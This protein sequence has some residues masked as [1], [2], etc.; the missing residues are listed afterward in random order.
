MSS[1]KQLVLRIIT[2]YHTDCTRANLEVS[3]WP[4]NLREVVFDKKIKF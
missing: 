1:A 3:D 4:H 2:Y